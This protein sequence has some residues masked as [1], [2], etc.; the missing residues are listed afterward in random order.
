MRHRTA[1]ILSVVLVVATGGMF[2]IESVLMSTFHPPLHSDLPLSGFDGN[3]IAVALFC[4]HYKWLLAVFTLAAV[5]V[6][7]TI[8]VFTSDTRAGETARPTPPPTGPPPAL[9]NP[10]AAAYW[11]LLFSPAFGAFVHARNADAMG[12]LDE[13][14]ANRTWFRVLIAYLG[15]VFVT[16]F[17]PAF[18]DGLLDLAFIGLLFGWYLSLGKK[19]VMYVKA[20]WRESY[21]RKPWKRLLLVASGCLIGTIIVSTVVGSLVLGLQ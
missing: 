6:L 10:K 3:L 11:S 18:P 8:A 4:G 7:L 12:R 21:E 17:I 19:Q 13:A 15:V 20:T 1:A 9:W 2:A 5:P 16:I 14:K